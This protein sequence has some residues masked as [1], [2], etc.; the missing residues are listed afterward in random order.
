RVG[1]RIEGAEDVY[2]EDIRQ[3]IGKL[4]ALRTLLGVKF[5]SSGL[6]ASLPRIKPEDIAVVLFTSGSEK[7]PKAVPL[8]HGNILHDV[9]AGA[10]AL[11]FTRGD[12]LL[13]FLPP[14]HSFGLSGNLVLPLVGG[15][16]VVHH[17]DPTDAA[18]RTPT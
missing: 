2:L 6:L 5:F 9:Q 16:R 1:V 8:T 17:G 15:V 11:G 13:G 7:A 4:E 18:G 10:S 14:F 3:E 12:I